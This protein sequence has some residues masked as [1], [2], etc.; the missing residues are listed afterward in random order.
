MI[1]VEWENCP[2]IAQ[3]VS[4]IDQK[5]DY[6]SKMANIVS[7]YDPLI[8]FT[9]EFNLKDYSISIFSKIFSSNNYSIIFIPGKFN[10]KNG[11]N[12]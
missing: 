1:L 8:Y 5:G 10:I 4:K 9:I 2:K 3:K 6:S 11:S 7:K 12:I